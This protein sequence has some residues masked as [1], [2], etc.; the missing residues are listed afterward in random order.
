MRETLLPPNATQEERGIEAATA[1][2]GKIPIEIGRLWNPETC[3]ADLLPWLAWAL[4]VDQW[5]SDWDE[6]TQRE[7]IQHSA[8]AHRYK[9]TLSSIRSLLRGLGFGEVTVIEGVGREQPVSGDP[10]RWACYR[11]LFQRLITAAE[12][13][14]LKKSLKAWAPARC[15]LVSLEY[16]PFHYDFSQ[17]ARYNGQYSYG[18]HA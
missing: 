10:E 18:S 3:P 7:V 13:K 9:G 16:P 11:V 6:R 14:M 1:R 5:H 4:S 2:L 12:A 15:H 8:R 17:Q